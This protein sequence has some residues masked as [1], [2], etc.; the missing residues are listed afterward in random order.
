MIPKCPHCQREM[1]L[2]T[3]VGTETQKQ[4]IC[5]CR[6]YVCHVNMPNWKPPLELRR[7]R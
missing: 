3:A 2:N 4:Y 7:R 1:Q 6:G 5:G